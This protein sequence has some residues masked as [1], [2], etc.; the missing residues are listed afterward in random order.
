MRL[1][2]VSQHMEAVVPKGQKA[3]EIVVK[4]E[5]AATTLMG[6]INIHERNIEVSPM[7]PRTQ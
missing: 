4:S 6:G 5:E 2:N 3:W 7:L 1:W